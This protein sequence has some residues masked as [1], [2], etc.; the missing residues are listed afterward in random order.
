MTGDG[1]GCLLVVLRF[2]RVSPSFIAL[3]DGSPTLT[4][5]FP[6]VTNAALSA[7]ALGNRLGPWFEVG[8]LF[9]T[10]LRRRQLAV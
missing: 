5:Q 2:A 4:V 6:S 8:Q 1:F 9:V 10:K 3:H 7:L